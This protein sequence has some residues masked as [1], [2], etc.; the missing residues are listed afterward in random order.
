MDKT[1]HEI[2]AKVAKRLI[3]SDRHRRRKSIVPDLVICKS[4]NHDLSRLMIKNEVL[5]KNLEG[6][7]SSLEIEQKRRQSE[8]LRSEKALTESVRKKSLPH[9]STKSSQG[10]KSPA[11]R[12]L[13][14]TSL[15]SSASPNELVREWL[16]NFDKT[17]NAC[18]NTLDVPR[19]FPSG[20]ESPR[21]TSVGSICSDLESCEE[22]IDHDK[23]NNVDPQPQLK[24]PTW[25]QGKVEKLG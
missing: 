10:K 15:Q 12:Q 24:V 23:N 3:H 17:E 25:N 20:M 18:K 9:L 21:K 4:K 8:L 11:L 6:K 22:E 19:F 2:Q 13:R 5:F 1:F 16:Q 14:R 7:M